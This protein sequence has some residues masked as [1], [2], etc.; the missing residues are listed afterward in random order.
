M[1]WQVTLDASHIRGDLL[2]SKTPGCED[3]GD[4]IALVF[5]L[6]GRGL[7]RRGC[8]CPSRTLAA[9]VLCCS[10]H[11]ADFIVDLAVALQQPHSGPFPQ[12]VIWLVCA[13]LQMAQVSCA[14]STKAIVAW[15]IE[16]LV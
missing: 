2:A 4:D 1:T 5:G 6:A 12:E 8:D 3:G 16:W 9:R 14:G 13:A 11:V 7:E 15:H 10:A